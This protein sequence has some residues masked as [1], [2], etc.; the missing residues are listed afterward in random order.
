MS[1]T[2]DSNALKW[3][4]ALACIPTPIAVLLTVLLLWYI[5]TADLSGAGDGAL[6]MFIYIGLLIVYGWIAV[7][8]CSLIGVIAAIVGWRR[9]HSDWAWIALALNILVPLVTVSIAILALL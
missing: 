8:I 2:Q 5:Q 9:A 7:L 6:G 4:V 3:S 1:Q